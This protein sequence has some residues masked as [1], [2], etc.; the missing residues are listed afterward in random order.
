MLRF[1]ELIKAVDFARAVGER[2]YGHFD[3]DANRLC[4]PVI[5]H[6]ES[7]TAVSLKDEMSET[8][9]QISTSNTFYEAYESPKTGEVLYRPVE[10]K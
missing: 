8:K 6:H 1:D 2:P 9:S 3:H 5:R 10:S 7:I 4:G